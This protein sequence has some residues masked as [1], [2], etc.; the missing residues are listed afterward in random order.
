MNVK[1]RTV[2]RRV[3]P[4]GPMPSA[5]R[6]AAI[7]TVIIVAACHT[8]PEQPICADGESRVCECRDRN[9][10]QANY[11]ADTARELQDLGEHAAAL[12]LI[13]RVLNA[14]P[15]FPEI[16]FLRGYSLQ[17]VDNNEEAVRAY[18]AQLT[19]DPEHR[20]ASFNLGY[21]YMSLEQWTECVD[22]FNRHL[23]IEPGS[24][25]SYFHLARCHDGLGRTSEAAA[26]RARYDNWE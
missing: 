19:T 18:Q 12:V 17:M 2:T 25:D 4:H 6:T 9:G 11:D 21:A 16:Q 8:E 13:Q 15:D 1:E 23:E 14:K 22:A 26:A 20:L 7:A 3:L 5:V 10:E 24:R